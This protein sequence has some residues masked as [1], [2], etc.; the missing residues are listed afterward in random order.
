MNCMRVRRSAFLRYPLLLAGWGV[1]AL[2]LVAQSSESDATQSQTSANPQSSAGPGQHHEAGGAEFSGTELRDKMF[3]RKAAA[4]GLLEVQ[5]GKLAQAQSQSEDVKQLGQRMVDDHTR[6]NETMKPIAEAQGVM[7]PTK[8]PPKEQATY[9]RMKGLS[10]EEFDREYIKAMAEGHHADLR[11]FR[12]ESVST[13][14]AS[15]RE[16]T[17]A[18]AKTIREHMVAVDAMARAKGIP[19]GRMQ[20]RVEPPPAPPQ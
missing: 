16:A 10:G 14:D 4:D 20:G 8:L 15:L 11:A 5:L 19:V 13:Q 3:L 1:L 6:L 17:E 18:G 2:P 12:S 7:L 9:E